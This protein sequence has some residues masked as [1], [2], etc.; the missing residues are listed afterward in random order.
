MQADDYHDEEP[1]WP[2]ALAVWWSWTWRMI[3]FPGFLVALAGRV[4]DVP[5]T[6]ILG[7]AVGLLVTWWAVRAQLRVPLSV[8]LLCWWAMIWRMALVGGALLAFV[9]FQLGITPGTGADYALG[10]AVAL[11][12]SAWAAWGAVWVIESQVRRG[13]L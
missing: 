13:R 9:S 1:R 5:E 7:F 6:T 2:M 4:L 3:L 8:S 10:I 12:T 11:P